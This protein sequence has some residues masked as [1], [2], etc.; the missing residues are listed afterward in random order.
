MKRMLIALSGV[1]I[2]ISGAA[3]EGKLNIAQLTVVSGQAE[4][5]DAG[6]L[7]LYNDRGITRIGLMRPAKSEADL[8]EQLT[9]AVTVKCLMFGDAQ[10][11]ACHGVDAFGARWQ[12]GGE[13]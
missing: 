2:G 4:V 10:S 9:L 1:V 3:A 7:D 8:R 12:L 13:R 11:A 5:I 6:A